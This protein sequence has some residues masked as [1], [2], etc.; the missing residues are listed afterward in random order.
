MNIV[1]IGSSLLGLQKLAESD[2]FTVIDVLC[3]KKRVTNELIKLAE[4]LGHE[5]KL[6]DW[7]KDFKELILRYDKSV[8]F[9][10]YQLDMLVPASLT[11]KYSFY[12]LHRGNLET[13]RGPNPDVWPI[14]LGEKETTMSLH[15]INDRID[16]GV[17]IDTYDVPISEVDNSMSVKKKLE[18]GL[19]QLIYSTYLFI[20]GEIQGKEINDGNYRPWVTEQDFT[21]DLGKDTIELISRKIR[22]QKQ[23]N[24][25]ILMYE[26]QKKYVTEVFASIPHEL[27]NIITINQGD[28]NI[29]FKVNVKPKYSPP[30]KFPIPKRI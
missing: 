24:G 11:N 10:I 20:I 29:S 3:L 4:I 9:F 8:P 13:N 23:Y 18:E 28:N 22:C 1:F 2:K 14:L 15:K 5:I 25:A 21:I 19:P 16:A 7:I 30:P 12:N 27:E 26:G 17:L 6:F